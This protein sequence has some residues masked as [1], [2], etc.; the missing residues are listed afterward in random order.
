MLKVL[1]HRGNVR[2]M[3]FSPHGDKAL[4]GLSDGTVKVWRVADWTA[5][6]VLTGHR[7][8]VE[9]VE[10][11]ADGELAYCLNLDGEVFVWDLRRYR[12]LNRIAVD[13]DALWVLVDPRQTHLFT[14]LVSGQIDARPLAAA[15]SQELSVPALD[16]FVCKIPRELREQTPSTSMCADAPSGAKR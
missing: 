16:N 5:V 1:T 9:D 13:R 2:S 6:A 10:I 8:F 11:T 4:I 15:S 7:T 3:R 12:N 14:I